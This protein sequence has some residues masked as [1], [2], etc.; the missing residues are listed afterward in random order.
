M[1]MNTNNNSNSSDEIIAEINMTPLIDIMLVLLIIF[2]VTST[3]ALESALNVELPKTTN[4]TQVKPPE[5]LIISLAH[6]GK[7]AVQGKIVPF[8]MLQKEVAMTLKQLKSDSVIF[9]GDTKSELGRAV[10]IMDIAKNAGAKNFSL[11]AEPKKLN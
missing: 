5:T 8:T 6:D 9:E 1:S 2:M 3:V 4:Q 10:E 7:V 11:A